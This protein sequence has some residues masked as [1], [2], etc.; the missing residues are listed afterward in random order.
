MGTFKEAYG[1]ARR[2]TARHGGWYVFFCQMAVCATPLKMGCAHRHRITKTAAK[3]VTKAPALPSS[4]LFQRLYSGQIFRITSY[5]R[6]R[7][8]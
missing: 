3:D 7:R 5:K 2:C 8:T 6:L 1:V 4:N